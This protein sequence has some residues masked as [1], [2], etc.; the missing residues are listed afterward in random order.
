MQELTKELNTLKIPFQFAILHNP[1]LFYRY[2]TGSLWLSR[3][4][5]FSI[6]TIL[7]KIYQA[8]QTEFFPNAPLFSKHLNPV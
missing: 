5:Y 8:R 4:S 7:R 2:D 3:S 6:Q 1:E